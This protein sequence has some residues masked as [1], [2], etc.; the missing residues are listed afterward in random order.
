[1]KKRKH[2]VIALSIFLGLI[3]CN[4]GYYLIV[5]FETIFKSKASSSLS[6]K[7]L[8][9]KTYSN[10]KIGFEAKYP[11][12][13]VVKEAE[14]AVEINPTPEGAKVYFSVA[15]RNDFESLEDVKKK[16]SKDLLVVP[17]VVGGAS[18]FKYTDSDFHESI[19]LLYSGK[20][21]IVRIYPISEEVNQIFSTF[22]FID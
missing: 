2:L 1:M 12:S 11:A 15:L 10:P 3:L 6:N 17:A 9:P 7:N 5:N 19:W 20:I 16:L 14:N 18:G 4:V 8:G 22:K 13:W 21:Y